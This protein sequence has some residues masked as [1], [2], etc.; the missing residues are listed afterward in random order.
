MSLRP[1]FAHHLRVVEVQCI[2]NGAMTNDEI[3]VCRK[4][5]VLA[6]ALPLLVGFICP[7]TASF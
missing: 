6:A 3:T 5:P 7:P 2:L 4:P 1:G